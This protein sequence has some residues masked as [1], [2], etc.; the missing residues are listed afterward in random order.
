[1][2]SLKTVQSQKHS[3]NFYQTII[4]KYLVLRER[5]EGWGE[6]T[7]L[8]GLHQDIL[9]EMSKFICGGVLVYIM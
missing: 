5:K 9:L 7:L 1:M 8:Y 6:I 4:M 3:N 2:E